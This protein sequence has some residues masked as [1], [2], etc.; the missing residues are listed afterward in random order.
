VADG[1]RL[2]DR[3]ANPMGIEVFEVKPG[4]ATKPMPGWNLQ[5]VDD[6]GAAPARTGT[7]ETWW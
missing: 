1:D 6:E 7:S 3:A 5:V 4:S 2:A